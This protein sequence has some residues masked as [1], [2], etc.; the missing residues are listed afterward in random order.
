MQSKIYNT[1]AVR[2]NYIDITLIQMT[3]YACIRNHIF[4]LL[5]HDCSDCKHKPEP[6]FM[7]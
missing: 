2:G 7:Q 3:T 1:D 6:L 4:D 5:Y